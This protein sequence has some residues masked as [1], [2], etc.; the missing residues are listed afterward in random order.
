MT[1][2]LIN[3]RMDGGAGVEVRVR[4]VRMRAME[5]AES[6]ESHGDLELADAPAST[7]AVR[8]SAFR[9]WAGHPRSKVISA[10]V[11]SAALALGI[12]LITVGVGNSVTGREQSNLPS[13]I[14]RIQ[15]GLGDKVLN[16]ANIVVDLAPGYTG[17][18]IID[19]VALITESTAEA[20]PTGASG[21]APPTTVQFNPD[22]VRFDAG[23]NTLS[24]QPSPRAFIERF[25]VGRHLVKVVY[26]KVT[27]SEASSLSY[28]WYFD[29]TA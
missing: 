5:T 14:E 23:T 28:T 24:F 13:E 19:D 17:R 18:L 21:A 1:L 16:Q 20:E 11:V 15:P 4:A 12:A 29:V 25:A 10:M 2:P 3:P 9:P 26:W 27:E 8:R 6:T 22:A 7:P